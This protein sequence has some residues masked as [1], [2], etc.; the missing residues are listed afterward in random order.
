VA[1]VTSE[2]VVFRVA[3]RAGERVVFAFDVPSL[4]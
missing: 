3:G 1:L 4:R 2:S